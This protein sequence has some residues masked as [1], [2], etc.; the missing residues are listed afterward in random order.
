[1]RREATRA[2]ALLPKE[3]ILQIQEFMPE[4]GKLSIP[5]KG[6]SQRF[7]LSESERLAQDLEI[8]MK[9]LRLV[10]TRELAQEYGVSLTGVRKIVKRTL[11]A[12]RDRV[13][14]PEPVFGKK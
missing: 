14:A 10:P 1:M 5:Q 3:L 9:S 11:E 7:L 6:C 8:T 2:A 13:D 4:G 12:L